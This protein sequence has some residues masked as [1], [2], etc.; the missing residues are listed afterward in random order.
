MVQNI[1]ISSFIKCTKAHHYTS[2]Q[3]AT[4]AYGSHIANLIQLFTPTFWL[5]RETLQHQEEP[6]SVEKETKSSE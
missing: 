5:N 3:E 2:D 4:K 6:P 1:K